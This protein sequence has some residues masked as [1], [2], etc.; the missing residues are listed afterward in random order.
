MRMLAIAALLTVV[1]S[2]AIAA[3]GEVCSTEGQAITLEQPVF[4]LTNDLVFKCPRIGDVTIPQAYQRG[5]R[6]VNVWGSVSADAT[7]GAP[8]QRMAYT[9]VLEKL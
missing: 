8:I 4:P 1:S 7:R 3:E 9:L 6:V 5:W 2:P